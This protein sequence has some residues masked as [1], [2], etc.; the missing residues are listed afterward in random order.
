MHSPLRSPRAAVPALLLATLAATVGVTLAAPTQAAAE[1]AAS[2]DRTFF[3]DPARGSDDAAGS[4]AQPWR[5]LAKVGSAALRPGDTVRLRAGRTHIGAL[6]LRAS[7]TRGAPITVTDYGRGRRPAVA[8]QNPCVRLAGD[9][10]VVS[11]VAAL[12]CGEAGFVVDGDHDTVTDARATGSV[13]GVWVREGADHAL[14]SHS[15]LHDNDLMAPGTTGGDDDH[16]A[17]GVDINGDHARVTRNLITGH[18][19][20]SPD[21]GEDGAAVEVYQAVGTRVDHNRAVDNLAFTELGGSRTS[22]TRYLRNRVSS[23]LDE[24]TFLMTRGGA[25]VWG[26]VN[27]TVA[28]RNRVRLTGAHSFG[29]GC[30]GGCTPRILTLRDNTISAGWYVGW[31]DGTFDSANNRYRGELWFDLGPGD[32]AGGR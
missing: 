19:A 4:K 27:G 15:R 14:V 11:R 30:Y 2:G 22:G 20:P 6:D 7:G 29:F 13:R 24:G 18:R 23:R 28:E 32:R 1:S 17:Q 26:P 8:G 3:V 10:V 25:Q 12:R 31:V 21:Y 5:T 9:W 16:G